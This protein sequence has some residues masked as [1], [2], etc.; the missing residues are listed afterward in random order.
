[1]TEPLV[2]ESIAVHLQTSRE[3]LAGTTYIEM[4]NELSLAE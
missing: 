3:G 4:T 2:G 1:M